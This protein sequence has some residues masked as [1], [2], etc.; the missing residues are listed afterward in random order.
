MKRYTHEQ[1]ALVGFEKSGHFFFKPPFGR[2]YDDGLVAAI[3]VCDMLER[4]SDKTLAELNN[5]LPKTWGSPTMSPH[6]SDE[7]KYAIV[8]EIAGQYQAAAA[9]GARPSPARRSAS[10][11]PST[12]CVS[13]WQMEPGGWCAPP[14]TNRNW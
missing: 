9:D 7:A 13:C 11:S 3:A 1:Q 6:C 5:A 14:P 10:S 2:G 4:N 8:A 12:A